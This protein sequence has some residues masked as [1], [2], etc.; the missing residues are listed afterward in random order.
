MFQDGDTAYIVMDFIGGRTL[1]QRLRD[2]GP[3]APDVALC[4]VPLAVMLEQPLSS[5]GLRPSRHRDNK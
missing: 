3:L 1:M 4:E 5:G 2:E